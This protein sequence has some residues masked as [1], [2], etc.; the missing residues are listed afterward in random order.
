MTKSLLLACAAMILAPS[1]PLSAAEPAAPT[2]DASRTTAGGSGFVIPVGWRVESKGDVTVLTVPEGDGRVALV[3]GLAGADA[4]AAAAAAWAAWQPD[5]KRPPYLVTPR[6]GREGWDERA[7]I[8]YETSP[9]E[10]RSILAIL[11]RKGDRW[12]AI[13][14]D[15]ADATREKRGAA[16]NQIISSFK[17]PGYSR[18]NFAGRTPKK[19]DAAK[20]EEIKGFLRTGMEQLGVPGAGVALIQDGKVIWEGG[21]GVKTLGSPDPVDA[22]TKFM[23]ASNT[24]G[25]STL[26]LATLVDEGKMAWDDP[27]TK[28]YPSF[29]LGSDATT[30]QTK[31]RHLVCACTGL[32]RKDM[33]W[34]FNTPRGTK[35]AAVFGHLAATQPTSGFGEVFQYNNLITTAGGM[36]GGHIAYPKLEIGAA[37]DKAMEERVFKPLGMY[38]TT[39]SF[40]EA[41]KGNVAYPHAFDIDGNVALASFDPSYSIVPYRPAGGAWSSAHDMAKYAALE[42]AKGVLPNGK[43]LVSEANLLERRKRGV[44]SGEG[45]WYG[46]GLFENGFY[47]VPVI[48][49]GGSLVGHKSNFYVLPDA[50]VAAVLLTNSDSGN[51]L[52]TPFMRKLLEVVYDGKPEAADNVKATANAIRSGIKRDREKLVSPP[53]AAAVAALAGVYSS[54]ELGTVKVEKRG[55]DVVFKMTDWESTVATKKNDDGTIS[56]VSTS[57][58]V[59]GV[60][61]VV[62]TMDGKRTLILRDAQHEYVLTEASSGL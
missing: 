43:R 42:L 52:L 12:A 13:L 3:E 55:R 33:E 53:D 10:K 39:F 26:M 17:A 31:M 47:G 41:I 16:F 6:P 54:P 24:K 22:H 20:V 29:K 46:M 30:A 57:P 35:A 45:Q 4:K 23:V 8:E 32:P 58:G 50:G 38:E 62:A 1:A 34:I 27:V 2:A 59:E 21:L 61:L 44:S 56:F 36:I 48:Y 28:H 19:L 37:Y 49:H 14:A 15:S 18:E 51:A 11:H 5:F 60:P 9:N 25:M 40:D 7:F